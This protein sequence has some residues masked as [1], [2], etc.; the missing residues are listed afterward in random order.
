MPSIKVKNTIN[1][2][3]PKWQD[4]SLSNNISIVAHTAAINIIITNIG[5]LYSNTNAK[6]ART[7]SINAKTKGQ[8]ISNIDTIIFKI[9]FLFIYYSSF[10]WLLY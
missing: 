3:M 1:N 2:P 10:F 5:K 6:S 8:T 4:K 9:V 7:G